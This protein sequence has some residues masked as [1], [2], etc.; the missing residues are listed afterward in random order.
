MT[1][2]MKVALFLAICLCTASGAHAEDNSYTVPGSR[3]AAH[4]V[5]SV[6]LSVSV[7]QAEGYTGPC[8]V[9]YCIV[10]YVGFPTFNV[11]A[12]RL[13]IQRSR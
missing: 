2:T 1:C 6:R 10:L 13:A 4:S 3:H 12:W 8:T 5:L 11:N 7:A 9:L